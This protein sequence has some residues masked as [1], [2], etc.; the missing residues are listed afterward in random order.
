MFTKV[1]T[2][3]LSYI[4]L[5]HDELQCEQERETMPQA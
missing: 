5:V 3:F 1:I 2:I 4:N